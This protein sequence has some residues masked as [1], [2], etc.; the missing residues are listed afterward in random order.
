MGQSSKRLENRHKL[1][2]VTLSYF[3][4]CDQDFMAPVRNQDIDI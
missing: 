2:E 3:W 4:C 1:I